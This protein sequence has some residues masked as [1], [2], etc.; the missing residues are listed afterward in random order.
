MWCGKGGEQGDAMMPF[1]FG[2]RQQEAL[3]AVQ[4]QLE[5]GESLLAFLDDV[6][7]VTRP[8][9]VGEVTGFWRKA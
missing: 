6:Y 8:E 2:R 7:V 5:D 4:R 1:F 9:R 3:Q